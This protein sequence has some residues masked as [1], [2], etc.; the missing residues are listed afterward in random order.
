MKLSVDFHKINDDHINPLRTDGDICHQRR[1]TE[2]AQN[3]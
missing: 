3:I 2:I 1:D